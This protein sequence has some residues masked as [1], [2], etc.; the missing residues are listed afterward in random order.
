MLREARPP[1]LYAQTMTT[2]DS[3]RAAIWKRPDDR[4]LLKVYADAL[5]TSGQQSAQAEF[6]QLALL[7]ERTAGQSKRMEALRRKHRGA[8]LGPARKFLWT[9]V[10]DRAR[11]GFI[12]R[13]NTAMPRFTKGFEHIRALGPRLVVVVTAPKSNRDVREFA[14]LPLGT[15]YG[16]EFYEDGSAKMWVNDF[17]LRTIG[18]SLRGIKHLAISASHFGA[19]RDAHAELVSHLHGL[20]RLRLTGDPELVPSLS[21]APFKESLRRLDLGFTPSKAEVRR[22]KKTFPRCDVRSDAYHDE[23]EW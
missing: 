6:I 17:L 11:P 4:D 7:D 21:D 14:A 13:C 1:P 2:L 3:L 22:W 12:A 18:P 19:T 10:E 23:D 15:M 8:W 5:E 20:E 9:W 16:L